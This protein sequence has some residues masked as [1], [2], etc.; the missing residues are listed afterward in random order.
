MSQ[1]EVTICGHSIRIFKLFGYA[2]VLTAVYYLANTVGDLVGK[3]G[4]DPG[5]LSAVLPVIITSTGGIV[6]YTI[7]RSDEEQLL[8]I[9]LVALMF[10][11]AFAHS[12]KVVRNERIEDAKEEAIANL[13][14]HIRY[15]KICSAE[16]ARINYRREDLDLPPLEFRVVCPIQ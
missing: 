4:P 2:V 6:L 13:E 8:F 11:L 12:Y 9:G 15:V 7:G 5:V 3:S 16:Q 14:T 1:S 10:Y